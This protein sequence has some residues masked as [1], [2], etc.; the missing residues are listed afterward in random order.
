MLLSEVTQDVDNLIQLCVVFKKLSE[1]LDLTSAIRYYRF[2]ISFWRLLRI[3][4]GR[5]STTSR[6]RFTKLCSL[7]PSRGRC[8]NMKE[9]H[10]KPPLAYHHSEYLTDRGNKSRIT[11][12]Y[13]Q[14]GRQH[15]Y[16]ALRLLF[17]RLSSPAHTVCYG[18][19]NFECSC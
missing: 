5:I 10:R 7:L 9:Q 17:F 19:S 18:S 11:M 16:R 4:I 1:D 15:R 14:R 6:K 2:R 12:M 3:P 13:R 8:W